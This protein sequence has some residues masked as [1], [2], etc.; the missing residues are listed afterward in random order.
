MDHKFS[1]SIK[2][3]RRT[4]LFKL[5]IHSGRAGEEMSEF[6]IVTDE[7]KRLFTLVTSDAHK[8][9]LL[10]AAFCWCSIQEQPV[11]CWQK[12]F[13]PSKAPTLFIVVESGQ[14]HLFFNG[15]N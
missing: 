5:L 15:R 2:Y 4:E 6:S 1:M 12:V 14:R 10:M 11:S 9:C 13:F 8:I 3:H 7:R